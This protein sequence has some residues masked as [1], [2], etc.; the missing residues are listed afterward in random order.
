MFL[1]KQIGQAQA[2]QV[3]INDLYYLYIYYNISNLTFE[4]D[5]LCDYLLLT[6]LR[7]HSVFK[8]NSIKGIRLKDIAISYWLFSY[9]YY[10]FSL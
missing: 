3:K 5:L 8:K 1:S 7:I 10:L 2:L 9:S 6:T 4:F